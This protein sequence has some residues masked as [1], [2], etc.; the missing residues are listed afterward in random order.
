MCMVDRLRGALAG[1]GL[2]WGWAG[3]L[4]GLGWAGAEAWKGVKSDV[5][6]DW[7]GEGGGAVIASVACWSS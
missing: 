2:G 5:V 7:E 1:A 4:A 3:A 6:F